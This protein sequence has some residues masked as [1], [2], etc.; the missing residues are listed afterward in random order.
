[1]VETFLRR[2]QNGF[3]LAETMAEERFLDERSMSL[4]QRHVLNDICEGGRSESLPFQRAS[5]DERTGRD[6]MAKESEVKCVSDDGSNKKNEIIL[7]VSMPL[8][9]YG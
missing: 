7:E 8:P 4:T 6:S 9:E 2:G 3:P 1:M 5:T